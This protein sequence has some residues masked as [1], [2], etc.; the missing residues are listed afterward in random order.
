MCEGTSVS[1]LRNLPGQVQPA[2]KRFYDKLGLGFAHQDIAK[3]R[4]QIKL[5]QQNE[6]VLFPGGIKG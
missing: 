4:G 2:A 3:P 1:S 5:I 6:P